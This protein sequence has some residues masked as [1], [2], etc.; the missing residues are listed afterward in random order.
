VND[1]IFVTDQG[2]RFLTTNRAFTTIT[3]YFQDELLGKRP[4]IF[5]RIDDNQHQTIQELHAALQT[6]TCWEGEIIARRK[7]QCRF[8]ALI[9]ITTVKDDEG[10]PLNYI[11]VLTDITSR[12]ET[13]ERLRHLATHD[14]L[15]NLPNRILFVDQLQRAV[16][17]AEQTGT[18]LAVLYI[19]LD[20]FKEINDTYGHGP[21][22]AFLK[23]IAQRLLEHIGNNTA[24][25]FG[26]DEFAILLEGIIS[27]EEALKTA[28]VLLKALAAPVHI[29]M[30]VLRATASIGISIYPNYPNPTSLLS[31]ADTAMYKAK[32]RGKNTV[33]FLS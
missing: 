23:V 28:R 32:S 8:P 10:R 16:W 7:N 21:G 13:E 26:G 12:K 29:E 4:D 24:A 3:G 2:G 15:T 20:G 18:K 22:D 33:A 27:E 25:R 5:V 11:G 9:K 30:N 6:M 14:I 17:Y 1:G 31:R 19:D